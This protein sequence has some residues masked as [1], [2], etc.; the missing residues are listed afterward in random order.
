MGTVRLAGA[1]CVLVGLAAAGAWSARMGWAD[2]QVRKETIAG[3]EEALHW[4]PGNAE[5][6]YRLA[7]LTA[8]T[9]PERSLAALRGAVERNPADAR[10]WIALGLA[11]EDA[12][13]LTEAE[14]CLR[15]AAAEDRGYLPRW[16]LANFYFRR[17]DW[18]HFWEW[19]NSAAEMVYDGGVPL[20]RLC[21]R[22]GNGGDV[23]DR[24]A[25]RRPDVRA[26][27]VQYLLQDG[28][29]DALVLA[30]RRVLESGR[31]A[32]TPLLL[33]ACGRLLETGRARDAVEVWNSLAAAHRIRLAPLAPERGALVT[34]GRF[35]TAPSGAGFDWRLPVVEGVSAA[36]EDRSGGL[37]LTFSGEQPENCDVL[38]EWVPVEENTDYTLASGFRTADIPSASGVTWRIVDV[39]GSRELAASEDLAAEEGRRSD[40]HFRTP[41]E[42]RLVRLS[43]SYHRPPGMTRI[44][45]YVVL[46]EVEI[47]AAA[48]L[49]SDVGARSRVR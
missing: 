17:D 11:R 6:E 43:L 21:G 14:R 48:Q 4:L 18:L 8:E 15:R 2:D 40:T 12:G 19:A 13:D 33:T 24:L 42:C 30:V 46:Q 20:F 31:E 26:G 7:L 5:Y 1:V 28:R 37:R 34:N 39:G 35:T 9:E 25:L 22:V 36:R 32:D 16:T 41:A 38:T 10:S 23:M 29:L 49:P 45:G 44:N 47:R 3:T 27:Y